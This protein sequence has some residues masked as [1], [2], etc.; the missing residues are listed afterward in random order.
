MT[1]TKKG[2]ELLLN[3]SAILKCVIALM[4]D[5]SPVIAKDASLLLINISAEEEGANTLLLISETSTIDADHNISSNLVNT[6]L[7]YIMDKNS[8]IADPCSMILSNLTRS[9]NHVER[10]I[11]LMEK[12]SYT[13]DSIVTAFTTVT[14]NCKGADLDYVATVLSNLS[15]S[16]SVRRYIMDKDRCVIQRLLPFTEHKNDVRRYGIV[17]TLRNCCFDI[18]NHDWLLGSE[19]DILPHILLPLAGPEE[20]PEEDNDK[21]PLDLQYLPETKERE[22]NPDIRTMLLETLNQLCA[23]KSGRILLR[24]KNA[25]AILREYHKWEKNKSILLACENVVD[26]LI[27]T[28]EEIGL[29]NLKDVDVPSKYEEEF[30]KMNEEF[31]SEK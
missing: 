24:E 4:Q 1:G 22:T 2:I 26:I 19:V 14:Y 25:Y 11:K 23:T 16:L 12:S 28:E 9:R 13:W 6:C 31:I 29:D 8:V 21:L 20:L 5:D 7:R 27:R 10:F 30:H 18:D 15:Q 3:T 17:A